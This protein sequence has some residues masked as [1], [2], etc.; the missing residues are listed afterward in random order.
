MLPV[1]TPAEMAEADRRTISAGAAESV[2][3]E[4]AGGAVFRHA[5]RM[6]GGSY[7][8]R[9]VVVCGKGNNGADGLV[10]ARRLRASGVGVDMF[11]L[12][13]GLDEAAWR[14]ALAR[15]DLA[16]DAMFGTGFRG[17]LAGDAVMVATSLAESGVVTLAIDIPSGVDGSTGAIDG[18]AVRALETV[19]FAALKPGLLFEP[20]RARAGIVHVADIGIV[21]EPV[22]SSASRLRVLE[23]GDVFVPRRAT[24]GHKWA[25]GAFVIGGS[26]GMTGAPLM[27][28]RAAARSGAGMVVCGVP[29]A[30]A[31]ARASGT[32]LVVRALRTTGDDAL[33]EAAAG[34]ILDG[35]DRFHALAIGPG[36]G[37][38][39]A[40]QAAVRRL[41]AECPI[42]I[43]VD[44][45]GL[46]AL[47][48]Q[49]DVLRARR[50]AGFPPAVLT[51]HGGEYARLAHRDVG[52]D[53]VAAARDLAADLDAIVLLKGPGTVIAGPDGDAIVNRTD[54]PALASA[55]TGDVLTG[56]IAG[57]L[58]AGAD[59]F[60]AAASGA[61][62]H[63]LAARA[64]GTGDS[65][66]ATDLLGVLAPT[67]NALRSDATPREG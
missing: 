53:R 65:L 45:D 60:L 34:E 17:A 22:A 57:L 64:A 8:R 27:A 61:Y 59:P 43:V 36:L 13:G 20:G 18:A 7:G 11:A 42:A 28:G 48:E 21:P 50:R 19:T 1:V 31:A 56:I 26:A 63:G 41:V 46:H 10:A 51:P 12:A 5:R 35:I 40:T 67:L 4:R 2:L 54:I 6:L 25:A 24:D 32:E 55:G 9:V 44:A 14:R 15:A 47:A 23:R 62:V 30:D 38:E 39:E 29:G 66:V 52:L 37:R 33:G 3:V 16:I 58:A 49:P